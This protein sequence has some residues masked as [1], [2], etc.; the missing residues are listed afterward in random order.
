MGLSVQVDPRLSALLRAIGLLDGDGGMRASWF[1]HPLEAIK[2]CL[3]NPAQRAAVFE[4]LD[5]ALPPSSGRFV[6]SGVNWHP[7]LE[8]NA[9]GNVFLTVAGDTIGVAAVVGTDPA[10]L[11]SVQLSLSL[12]LV[13][14]GGAT[15]QATVGPLEVLVAA[16]L[17]PTGSPA[18]VALRLRIETNG[19]LHLGVQLTDGTTTPATTVEFDPTMLD[20]R[21][22]AAIQLLIDAVLAHELSID[23]HV[24]RLVRHLPGMLGL[25]DAALTP[26]PLTQPALLRGWLVGIATSPAALNR[27]FLHLAGALG[28]GDLGQDD[29]AIGGAGVS[30]NPWRATVL[31]LPGGFEFQLTLGAGGSVTAPTLEVGVALAVPAGP[32]TI[33]GWAT[34]AA[35]PL[36]A[37][38][39]ATVLPAAAVQVSVPVSGGFV[40]GGFSFDGVAVKPLLRLANVVVGGQPHTM[41]LSDAHAIAAGATTLVVD[42]LE[43]LIGDAGTGRA[44]LALLGL[45]PPSGDLSSPHTL[46][47]TAFTGNLLRAV[48]EVHR[49]ALDDAAHPWSH[50][51]GEL[52]GLLGLA[53]TGDGTRQRPWSARLAG[54]DGFAVALVAWD[55]RSADT[56][57][58]T[59][60]LRLGLAA[61]YTAAGWE[62]AWA[63]DLAAFDLVPG[64]DTATRFVG[65]HHL[66]LSVTALPDIDDVLGIAIWA[67]RV[68]LDLGWRPGALPDVR[69]V[70]AGLAVSAGEDMVGPIDL[71]L[72]PRT[73]DLTLPDLGLGIAPG[74]L[75]GLARLLLGRAWALW[76][77]DTTTHVLAG[78][79]GL[80]HDLAGLPFDWAALPELS[81][82]LADPLAALTRYARAVLTGVSSDGSRLAP[83]ALRWVGA[84]LAGALP[85]T[86]DA[87][88]PAAWA[89]AAGGTRADPW[90][91][92]LGGTLDA[93]LLIWLE[94]GTGSGSVAAP[95][96]GAP[97]LDTELVAV[98]DLADWLTSGDGLLTYASQTAVPST[99]SL[100]N[101]AAVWHGDLAADPGVI[102]QVHSQLNAWSGAPA[103]LVGDVDWAPLLRATDPGHHPD[104]FVDL[105]GNPGASLDGLTAA[106]RCFPVQLDG[107][108]LDGLV[109]QLDR[110]AARVRALTGSTQLV[111][112]GYGPLGVTA[113]VAAART[114]AGVRGVITLAAPHAGSDLA[115]LSD[116][117]LAE[118]VRVADLLLAE[119]A[120]AAGTVV[121]NLRTILD[122]GPAAGGLLPDP[123]VF[124]ASTFAGIP[125][126]TVDTVAG[127]AIGS[128][129]TVDLIAA[130]RAVPPPATGA[131][132]PISHVAVGVALRLPAPAPGDGQPAVD[133]ELCA[134]LCRIP[135]IDQ[136][137]VAGASQVSLIGTIQRPGGWLVGDPGARNDATSRA[138]LRA[139][140]AQLGVVLTADG[141][142]GM[143]STPVVRLYEAGL[144]GNT[145]AVL[146]V[147]EV[148]AAL[149][150]RPGRIQLPVLD[151]PAGAFL[152]DCLRALGLTAAG[153]GGHDD[154][155]VSAAQA[156]LAAPAVALGSRLTA[157]LAVLA[158]AVGATSDG[159]GWR[160][161]LRGGQIQLTLATGPWSLRLAA[162]P[163]AGGAVL[164][165]LTLDLTRTLPGLAGTG[166]GAL[167]IGPFR[168]AWDGTLTVAVPPWLDSIQL[169][170][171]VVGDPVTVGAQLAAALP[172]SLLSAAL[173]A[174]VS[175][176]VGDAVRVL[177]LDQLLL[178]PAGF[179][180]RTLAN[181]AGTGFDP[182][183]L[184]G[185]LT[186]VSVA[187]GGDDAGGLPL[188]G[189]LRLDVVSPLGLK[190]AGSFTLAGTTLDVAVTLT[191][192]NGPNT[193]VTISGQLGLT[194]NLPAVGATAWPSLHIDIGAAA[195]GLTL[196]VTPSGLSRIELVPRFDGLSALSTGAA[197]LLPQILQSLVTE[198][199]P[200]PVLA[201]VL[202]VATAL[203]I[204]GNDPQGF[205][206]PARSAKLASMLQPG[207][208][209]AQLADAPTLVASIAAMFGPGLLPV[210]LGSVSTDGT[211][212]LW[213]THLGTGTISAGLG[214]SSAGNPVVALTLSA[215]D[216]GP[217]VLDTITLGF[218]GDFLI[219]V[220]A[221]LDIEG[222]LKPL[223]VAVQLAV[224]NGRFAARILPLG[225][226]TAADLSLQLAPAIAITATPQAAIDLV[227]QWGLPLVSEVLLRVFDGA[228]PGA[229]GTPVLERHFWKDGPTAR[230]ILDGAGLVP[231]ASPPRLAHPLPDP[232]VAVLGAI[233]AAATGFEITVGFE[234]G[235]KLSLVT[236][237]ITHRTGIRL[238]GH[239][240]IHTEDVTVSIKFGEATWLTDPAA[241]ITVWLVERGPANLPQ[242]T[243][244]ID[245]IGIGVVVSGSTAK[246]P[247]VKGAVVIGGAGGL[248]FF[249]ANFLDTARSPA[250]LV[251]GLGA[252]LGVEQAF[253]S[254]GAGDADSF[255]AT[256]L[257]AELKSPF[258][259]ALVYR[260]GTLSIEGTSPL[261]TGRIEIIVPMDLDLVILRIT[262]LL[263]GMSIAPGSVSLEAALSGNA[264][265]GPLYAFV[266]RVGIIATLGG[267][268]RGLRLRVPD[269]VGL[270]IDTSTLRLGGF[271]E[272]DEPHG[273]Y[274]GG[275]EISVLGK[276]SI[277]AIGIITTKPTFSLLFIV[278]MELPVP[279]AI[280]YGFFFAGAGG[281]LGINRSVDLDRLRQGLR[282]GTA[283]SI[284][285][286]KDVV[287]RAE[288][289]VT[290][291][292][293][294]FPVAPGQFLI[295][296]MVLITWSTPP[297]I[298]IKVGLI[299]EI[300]T[301]I[302]IAI[303][304]VLRAALPSADEAIIDIKVAFLGAIDIG[305]SLLSFDASIYDSF[306]GISDFK[307]SL[308]GDIAVRLSWG[309]HPDF[310]M[311]VGGFHPSY[312][313]NA[314]LKL[315]AMRRLSLSLLKDNPRITLSTYFAVTA[316]SVQFG[317]KLE[318]FLDIGAFSVEG[319]FGFDVL[320]QFSPFAFDARVYAKLAVKAGGSVVLGINVDFQLKGPT[321]WIVRGTASFTILF[322]T[323]SVEFEKRFGPELT[324]SAPNV[325]VLPALTDQLKRVANWVGTLSGTASELVS[326][327]PLKPIGDAVVID[328]AGSV[329]VG[330]RVLPLNYEFTRF[331][332]A[333]PSDV[334]KVW[335]AEL[336]LG[337]DVART[338]D[339][340]EPF[341]P[342]AFRVLSD[343]DKLRVPAFEQQPAGVRATAG[344]ALHTDYV[345]WRPATY[346]LIV[347][348][349]ADAET[350][351][352]GHG[353]N[354]GDFEAQAAAGA[355]SRSSA[356]RDRRNG[357]QSV[358]GVGAP[359][360]RYG[361]TATADLR[362]LTAAGAVA[363]PGTDAF[364]HLVYPAGVLLTRTDAQERMRALHTAGQLVQVIPEAQLVPS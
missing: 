107:Y 244:E 153:A 328:G 55:D 233:Q 353:G 256:V 205:T 291:L 139:R 311:S 51:F 140:S 75:A 31:M 225:P 197:L 316:N 58:H 227:L 154:L 261:S 200:S 268:N 229:S 178:D 52:T 71:V 220:L 149:A 159:T 84:L 337:G 2:H 342:A 8:D 222:V 207:W 206:A 94:S 269:S 89:L 70:V 307:L 65:T 306:I 128:R 104:A 4:L 313:P 302:R 341:S 357:T 144:R 202:D 50:V 280:G 238:H 38:A 85:E 239:Q 359:A 142:G 61:T 62:V 164:D 258:D 183:A 212:V 253:I 199:G 223:N 263:L 288:A 301:P 21:A 308:E 304:G 121:R 16:S 232:V 193:A 362:P 276:F 213:S 24:H 348:D 166:T 68:D 126:G 42:A 284:L 218:D 214:W 76:G 138:V 215:I 243:A 46:D 339:V 80:H 124:A 254:I 26:L 99:W 122:G 267:P 112:L 95:G 340:T 351:T 221:H 246:G 79:F 12:P 312:T 6:P 314:S 10:V 231:L 160:L 109:G 264:T 350:R 336:R 255:L 224:A 39:P 290:D 40:D 251:S 259:L 188:P 318:F 36:T 358:L 147:P 170:P 101:P 237:P 297:L 117:G 44:V 332:T 57:A 303:L 217:A 148:L 293:A 15:V 86:A 64:V 352:P 228:A 5:S 120:T 136:P 119:S 310:V 32:G 54:D 145:A 245:A 66:R 98:P 13:N 325:A 53:V 103:L 356:G 286:P 287:R 88:L 179:L 257:P 187:L 33:N 282:A 278:T 181:P 343:A 242:L 319:Y 132:Q 327:L 216:V 174:L 235:L 281:L 305:A 41:D 118:A 201:A 19:H 208:L 113:R 141:S 93:D 60:L 190:L 344:A 184:D 324:D 96:V 91:L 189:G 248:L 168:L 364:G 300:G 194:V 34:L 17:D 169:Y 330:Q 270:S 345:V 185:L 176:V 102:D 25:G 272:V 151:G 20:S 161:Q 81:E 156:A 49:L 125:A 1:E 48:A 346:D 250:L 73:F 158:P 354:K 14:T 127:L 82:L 323:I 43:E 177:P 285:F 108:D 186:A 338:V 9:Y 78:L 27:W 203:G 92:P 72:P 114:P 315:P 35:I 321:P 241:G 3:D 299:L 329:T 317:A 226:G 277:S 335:I 63:T 292:E 171:R 274:I 74:E 175:P 69:V 279:I 252:G 262:E 195:T 7:M 249:H 204:Y 152:V 162:T 143:T 192:P 211:T 260:N 191:L 309:A 37:S 219:D 210:P 295:G 296:P 29:P 115:P 289:I 182:A 83:A 87:D 283:D 111:L 230:S 172:R 331:G 275:I 47:P 133:L 247:L 77:D 347:V 173:A 22:V 110:V 18:A 273:R 134:D 146:D 349:E 209:A 363:T 23:P 155:L 322:F 355:A 130:I 11:P 298:S 97:R 123:A 157:L 105:R 45:V 150:V 333:V 294:V 326:L 167:A 106:A 196:G 100:G 180:R 56:P 165:G 137:P 271:L 163:V 266:K 67:D 28:A 234:G 198:L 320:F 360:D 116:V 240:D 131:A 361:V 334:S 129:L 265:L 236:D 135:V 59:H 30:G 90:R